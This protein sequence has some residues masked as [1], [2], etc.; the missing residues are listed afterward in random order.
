MALGIFGIELFIA[1]FVHDALIRPFVGDALVVVLIYF[2]VATF[3][4]MQAKLLIGAVFVFACGV[5]LL[6]G[7]HLVSWLGLQKGSIAWV[8][9]GATFDWWD[10]AAYAVGSFGLLVWFNFCKNMD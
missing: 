6:Q 3:L 5:E 9:L 1:V 2:A 4:D 8:V 10:I 7:M